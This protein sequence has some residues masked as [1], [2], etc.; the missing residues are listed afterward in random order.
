MASSMVTIP[1]PMD[2]RQAVSYT[3]LR[4]GGRHQ[5]GAGEQ[6]VRREVREQRAGQ[7]R[8]PGA[9]VCAVRA[10]RSQ[11]HH[12]R[13][14]DHRRRSHEVV[15]MTGGGARGPQRAH[16]GRAEHGCVQRPRPPRRGEHR[17]R[18]GHHGH[19]EAHERLAPRGPA[20]LL[21]TAAHPQQAVDAGRGAQRDQQPR[22]RHRSVH[23][24]LPARRSVEGCDAHAMRSARE[25]KGVHGEHSAEHEKF[26]E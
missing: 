14:V 25:R 24:H 3:H 10:G 21:D 22:C 16:R 11:G 13:H 20:L 23:A 19:A 9:A 6:H 15:Q 17:R 12:H 4:D 1:I 26:H 5:A 18:Y 7:Q 2:S 8:H